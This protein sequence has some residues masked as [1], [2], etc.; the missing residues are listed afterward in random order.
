MKY[1]IVDNN[2]NKVLNIYVMPYLKLENR[3]A[4]PREIT[5]AD[6]V[7]LKEVPDNTNVG[8]IVS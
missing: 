7:T 5:T 6:D 1:V 2:T 3:F 8:D 4:T